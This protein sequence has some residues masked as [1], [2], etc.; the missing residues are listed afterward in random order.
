MGDSIQIKVDETLR[1]VLFKVQ[2]EVAEEFKKRYNLETVTIH[3]TIASQILAA[4]YRGD[5]IV[6]FKINKTS[7]NKGVLEILD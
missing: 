5:K 7:L 6:N 2:K 1:D 3:G 4:K